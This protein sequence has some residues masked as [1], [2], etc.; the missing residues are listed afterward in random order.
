MLKLQHVKDCRK[1]S[2]QEVGMKPATFQSNEQHGYEYVI[3][4]GYVAND[5]MVRI[6]R[7]QAIT[8]FRN[9]I[10]SELIQALPRVQMIAEH[11]FRLAHDAEYK[12][13]FDAKVKEAAKKEAKAKTEQ[14]KEVEEEKAKEE[15]K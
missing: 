13:Y 6:T 1:I 4:N 5:E 10:P 12:K 15:D 11:E 9:G 2:L 14:A 7:N 8:M 3:D